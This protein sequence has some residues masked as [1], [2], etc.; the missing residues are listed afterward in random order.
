MTNRG[1]ETVQTMNELEQALCDHT[2]GQ[3]DLYLE[4]T[5]TKKIMAHIE[6]IRSKAALS[7]PAG[8]LRE[9]ILKAMEG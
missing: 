1:I 4:C 5:P 2:G 3:L 8:A 6:E 7:T 9:R